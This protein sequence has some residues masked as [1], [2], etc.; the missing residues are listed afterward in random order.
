MILARLTAAGVNNGELY[1]RLECES[2][3]KRGE[4]YKARA[5]NYS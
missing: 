5:S 1:L 2:A 3:T 4:V